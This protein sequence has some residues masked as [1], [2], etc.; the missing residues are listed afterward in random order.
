MHRGRPG[1]SPYARYFHWS[2]FSLVFGGPL[3]MKRG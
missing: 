1:F 2:Q 3:M